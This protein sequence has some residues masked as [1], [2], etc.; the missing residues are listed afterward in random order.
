MADWR[1]RGFVPDS[2]DEDE[3]AAIETQDAWTG[4]KGLDANDAH[5]DDH[6]LDTSRVTGVEEDNSSY[7]AQSLGQGDTG[8]SS[9]NSPTVKPHPFDTSTATPTPAPSIVVGNPDQNQKPS[10][11]SADTGSPQPSEA[12]AK[13]G[14]QDDVS[15]LQQD[16]DEATAARELWAEDLQAARDHNKSVVET[17]K[18][19]EGI[20]ISSRS[21]SPLTEP[22]SSP[23]TEPFLQ[24]VSS[25]PMRLG[26]SRVRQL[27]E[28][29]RESSGNMFEEQPVGQF[30]RAIAVEIVR[31]SPPARAM[32]Q[33]NPI[34]LHPYML[35][36]ERYRQ[37]LKAR[38]VKPLRIAHG[39]AAALSGDTDSQEKEFEDCI[40]RRS[41]PQDA[42]PLSD[43]SSSPSTSQVDNQHQVDDTL[44]NEPT[45]PDPL[46]D[47]EEFP[48]VDSLLRGP[49]LDVVRYGHKRRKTS[50]LYG[51]KDRSASR[52]AS[53]AITTSV[54]QVMERDTIMLGTEDVFDIPPSPPL[55]GTLSP[56]V[57]SALPF[58]RF[59][60][61]GRQTPIRLETPVTSSAP[62]KPPAIEISED[63]DS[64]VA[65]NTRSPTVSSRSSR[66]PSLVSEQVQSHQIERAQRKIRGVLPA[67]WLR[68]DLRTQATKPE[69]NTRRDHETL[70]PS[71]TQTHRGVA[72]KLT[73]P[74]HQSSDVKNQGVGAIYISDD[75][76]ESPLGQAT[77]LDEPGHMTLSQ[78]NAK[79]LHLE[80]PRHE[81]EEDD[82][83]DAMLPS[84]RRRKASSLLKTKRQTRLPEGNRG[85]ITKQ[86]STQGNLFRHPHLGSAYQPRITE[87]LHN[88]NTSRT[89]AV[90]NRKPSIPKLS[91]LDA[92]QGTHSATPQFIRLAARQ[93][94][95]RK[96]RGRHSPSRKYI[97]LGN[98][99]DTED[100]Q[101]V[102]RQWRQGTM[103][104]V[105]RSTV[106]RAKELYNREPLQTTSGNEQRSASFS[107]SLRAPK[108]IPVASGDTNVSDTD[109]F[110]LNPIKRVRVQK[111]LTR[112]SP[113]PHTVISKRITTRRP[114]CRTL[115][116][117]GKGRLLSSLQKSSGPRLAQLESR[118]SENN[119][120]PSR[121]RFKNTLSQIDRLSDH[122]IL[123]G[124]SLPSLP[125]ARF[126]ET[127]ALSTTPPS[128]WSPK[129]NDQG[130][131]GPVPTRL[132]KRPRK[133]RPQ[134]I[135]ADAVDFRQ[136]TVQLRVHERTLSCDSLP[137]ECERATLLGLA[138]FGTQYT[139]DFDIAPLA[140]G[141]FFHESTFV[142]SGEF[143]K[144]LR[145]TVSRELDVSARVSVH[146]VE[147][148]FL[149]WGA[150]NE[151]VSSEL[152]W[153][154]D[155]A[156]QSLS[157]VPGQ[158]MPGANSGRTR[159][160]EL[161]RLLRFIIRYFNQSISFLDPIDR[162]SF[163]KRCTSLVN[164][165]TEQLKASSTLLNR[166]DTE[167]TPRILETFI[168]VAA[169]TL[170]IA[171]QIRQ[172]ALHEA[173]DTSIIT[174]VGH[175]VK[176]IAC[177][178]VAKVY[179]SGSGTLRSFLE[180]NR[181][182]ARREAGIREDNTN[183]ETLVITNHVLQE[184]NLSDASIWD[185]LHQLVATKHAV[186]LN[187]VRILELI[188]YNSFTLLPL[189]EFDETGLLEVGRRF[190]NSVEGWNVVKRV[191]S[192]VL[193]I[194]LANP[195]KQSA[196]FNNYL[197][198]LFHRCLHL[199]KGWGWQRCEAIIGTLF[200]FFAHN[201][202]AHLRHEESY[203]SPRFLQELDKD[204]NLDMDPDDRCYHI[205][206]K[207]IGTGLKAMR[208]VYPDKKIRNIAWRLMPNHG[209]LHPKDK[210][211]RQEDLDALRNHHDLL[212]T[213]Y[214]ASPPGF[215]PRLDAVRNLVDPGSS[216]R[217]ACH[218]SIRAWS[219]LIRYQLSTDEPAASLLPFAIWHED[220]IEQMLSQ[221]SLARGEAES[222]F[223]SAAKSGNQ[224]ISTE[225][226]ESTISTNQRQVEAVVS[227]ALQA[228]KTALS[229]CRSAAFAKALFC[230]GK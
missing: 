112:G 218:I 190:R 5:N 21:S 160:A 189:L 146:Q 14:D 24:D 79:D 204:P 41:L 173:V 164:V 156:G 68:L 54:G 187:D 47:T 128:Q 145:F 66:S 181:Q 205:L 65:D 73:V 148:R 170:V 195:E 17:E 51:R 174:E 177:Y 77:S 108:R 50:H 103:A 230:H 152:G 46:A 52:S 100:A 171:N 200:D 132:I 202:L 159:I 176:N 12:P 75:S 90:V 29:G 124:S 97:R 104:P 105:P 83:I 63:S 4:K 226:L 58:S 26:E 49:L 31:A 221:H 96:D 57:S 19:H 110:A 36:S 117:I 155:W 22:P 119:L 23:P 94:R 154:I 175:L 55:S 3:D 76:D 213:I 1:D 120:G 131:T 203:G 136:P 72:R 33:R 82:R 149:R 71:R 192:I 115:T 219:N 116:T 157:N 150:W 15:A 13:N 179:D 81:V 43:H 129:T 201:N 118:E 188:W 153:A 18:E 6:L 74:R 166:D 209:R 137:K 42:D 210:P 158:D 228:L 67:S 62:A 99:A 125:L 197:R 20:S 44:L 7:E 216:H 184:A 191:V 229:N 127:E 222:Q 161:I 123:G 143:A 2:D 135:D 185:F 87:H 91:V 165:L 107:A 38:G 85:R 211:V 208:H 56:H 198:A 30:R 215:R 88:P 40:D 60:F 113:V 98:R 48:D 11:I 25:S 162:S 78:R 122:R 80:P 121:S 217:E 114:N 86:G 34:Q 27:F 139:V 168:H 172:I 169:C 9:S 151:N 61:P 102:L 194:S 167:E 212:C 227:D 141:T 45:S 138:P 220:F 93:A 130:D 182:R 193:E 144:S 8:G 133:R 178:I 142:G 89:R 180:D 214:W 147:D 163:V 140:V 111:R 207:I 186:T 196:T 223:T 32:R 106:E 10:E 39:Q 59:R 35:E 134:Y 92:P 16:G 28:Q 53:N 199:I 101:S 95:S 70:S 225:L 69:T 64:D 37:S 206:L 183:V 109:D 224:Y 126:L 84:Q